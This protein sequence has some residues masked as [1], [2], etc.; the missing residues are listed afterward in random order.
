MGYPSHETFDD[1]LT[2]CV[3]AVEAT[4]C[5][6]LQ[7]WDDFSNPESQ[8]CDVRPRM[9]WN[10]VHGWLETIGRL[11]NRPICISIRIVELNGHRVAFW[12]ATSQLVDYEMIEQWFEKKYPYLKRT[13]AM[14]VHNAIHYIDKLSTGKP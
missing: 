11:D 13:D 12:E 7:I 5:E 4:S 2:S 3:Y 1:Y 8:Y 14:N 10:E 9:D 6:S